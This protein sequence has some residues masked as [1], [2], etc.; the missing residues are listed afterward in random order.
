MADRSDSAA[1]TQIINPLGM[2]TAANYCP[3]QVRLASAFA[4]SDPAKVGDNV[5]AMRA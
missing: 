1:E 4:T 2:E 5:V 3:S